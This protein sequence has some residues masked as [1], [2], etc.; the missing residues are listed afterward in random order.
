MSDVNDCSSVFDV[1]RVSGVEHQKYEKPQHYGV[2]YYADWL[3]HL[4]DRTEKEKK[5]K[6][7]G[8]SDFG[9]FE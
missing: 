6:G 3:P 8:R 1:M 7:Q 2:K 4:A 5:Q 9:R